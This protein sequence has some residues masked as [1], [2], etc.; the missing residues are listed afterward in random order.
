MVWFGMVWYGLV[1]YGMVGMCFSVA[2]ATL[3]SQMSVCLFV[4]PFVHSSESK[5]PKHF[6]INHPSSSFIILH[7]PSFISRLLSFSACFVF[8]CHKMSNFIVRFVS[9]FFDPIPD[10]FLDHFVISC[11]TQSHLKYLN[12]FG[13]LVVEGTHV[14][15]FTARWEQ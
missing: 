11:I 2:K 5:T 13:V 12:F 15:K 10:G 14:T 6:K 7:H 8:F 1:W 4:R 3:Q 9:N